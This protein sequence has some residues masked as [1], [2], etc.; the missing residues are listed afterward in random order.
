[1]RR[2]LGGRLLPPGLAAY[3]LEHGNAAAPGVGE[4]GQRRAPILGAVQ[5][6]GRKG[7]RDRWR[8]GPIGGPGWG[9]AALGRRAQGEVHFQADV[10]LDAQHAHDAGLGQREVRE[11]EGGPGLEPANGSMSLGSANAHAQPRCGARRRLE[12]FVR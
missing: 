3:H 7:K 5:E 9:G 8:G 2:S 6:E 12:R 4:T 10:V 1:M 11:R